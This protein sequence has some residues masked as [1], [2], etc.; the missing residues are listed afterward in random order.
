MKELTVT[1]HIG[2]GPLKLGMSPE[3]ILKAINIVI[4]ALSIPN[5]D[6]ID[7]SERKEEDGFTLRYIGNSF[8]FMVIYQNNKAVEI[9]VNHEITKYASVTLYE[10]EIFSTSAEEL[11]NY[12]S[13]ISP[14]TYDLDDILL[15]TNYEFTDIGVRLWRELAFHE[16][17]LFDKTY[18]NDMSQIIDE[19]YRYLYFELVAV[20]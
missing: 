9:S 12:L 19:M 6:D 13:T 3:Q 18:M 20:K 4:E 1:P 10:K 7:I 15:S 17:L 2:I 8:F 5:S 16:K 11:V 14:C